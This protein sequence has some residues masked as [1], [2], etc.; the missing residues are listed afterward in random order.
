MK[1]NDN[2]YS[3]IWTRSHTR[4]NKKKSDRTMKNG[5]NKKQEQIDN[6]IEN[7]EY[8][9]RCSNELREHNRGE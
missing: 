9:I 1:N 4:K 7:L 8:E 2:Y 6:Q 5:T 3:K